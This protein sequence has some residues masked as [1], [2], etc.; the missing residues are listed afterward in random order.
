MEGRKEGGGVED[1]ERRVTE[2]VTQKDS[3]EERVITP[4]WKTS[5]NWV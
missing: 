3:E 2:R 1:R 5:D 4:K